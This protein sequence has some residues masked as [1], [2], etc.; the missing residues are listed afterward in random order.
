MLRLRP[1]GWAQSRGATPADEVVEAVRE[2]V[3]EKPGHAGEL[4]HRQSRIEAT[5]QR[6]TALFNFRFV[7]PTIAEVLWTS[8]LSIWRR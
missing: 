2:Q 5:N 7:G 6:V 1:Q 8:S 3:R 4:T